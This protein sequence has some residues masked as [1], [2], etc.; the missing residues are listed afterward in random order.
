MEEARKLL[1][2][3]QAEVDMI[4]ARDP[5]KES[6]PAAAPVERRKR[7]KLP[8]IERPR[9][10]PVYA[11]QIEMKLNQGVGPDVHDI[12]NV[13]RIDGAMKTVIHIGENAQRMQQLNDC[14]SSTTCKILSQALPGMPIDDDSASIVS[15]YCS[16]TPSVSSIYS[17]GNYK[18]LTNSGSVPTTPTPRIDFGQEPRFSR[19]LQGG[20]DKRMRKG[21]A[22]RPSLRP[23]SLSM[24]IHTVQFEKGPGKKGLGFSVVG[25][26]DSPKGSMGIFVKT[27]FPEGQAADDRSLK[28]GLR[29]H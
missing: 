14:H 8:M 21:T 17:W 15:S 1:R 5:E 9:S 24:S 16:E 27:I 19:Q 6:T 22:N 10:A 23:K 13:S 11:G 25:G 20:V 7:R 12:C 18:P 26:I 28:E 4:I 3:C 2:N 29:F